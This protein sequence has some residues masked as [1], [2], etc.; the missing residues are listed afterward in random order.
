MNRK[1][2]KLKVQELKR[3]KY[4][5]LRSQNRPKNPQKS[6]QQSS[7]L[8]LQ[9]RKQWNR[10]KVGRGKEAMTSGRDNLRRSQ[11]SHPIRQRILRK[12]YREATKRQN[13]RKLRLKSQRNR[14]LSRWPLSLNGLQESGFSDGEKP[15]F[16][17]ISR[18]A[19]STPTT[20]LWLTATRWLRQIRLIR[21]TKS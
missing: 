7:S 18:A 20:N 2:T 11:P 13:Q 14:T 3:R 16:W 6:L 12:R 8:K 5:R 9:L 21:Q 15:C 17:L 1:R 10:K 4:K 19:Y